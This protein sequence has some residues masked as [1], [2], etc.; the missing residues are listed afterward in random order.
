[1]IEAKRQ[2]KEFKKW[3]LFF[4]L[5]IIGFF[6]SE[7][8]IWNIASF[9]HILSESI[10]KAVVLSLIGILIYV[11]LFVFFTDVIRR[12][13]INDF[14]GLVLLGSVYGLLLEGIFA[15]KVFNL[16]GF[17][18][19]IAG[20]W[21]SNL[22]FTALSWHPLID[23]LGAFF[24]LK[25]FL[26][27]KISSSPDNIN[28]KEGTVIFFFS[29]FWFV[30]SFAPWL[31]AKMPEE[32]PL[33][34]EIFF[35]LF[36]AILIL[37]GYFILKTKINQLPE[38]FLGKKFYFLFVIVFLIFS[39][40]RFNDL[41][42]K[43]SFLFFW[44]IIF[45]YIFLFLLYAKSRKEKEKS[46]L[47]DSFP[48][49]NEMSFKKMVKIMFFFYFCYFV[50]KVVVLYFPLQQYFTLLNIFLYSLFLFFVPF[51]FFLAIFKITWNLIKK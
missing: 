40:L 22:A 29:F 25:I 12:F 28:L 21:G 3:F 45:L 41:D 30:F 7:I 42:N 17:S 39:I 48:I 32:L 23:F 34:A 43:K 26:K 8:L 51:F 31:L 13:K 18:F 44:L 4:F 15:D 1:M 46:I 2:S 37:I 50:F 36:P 33:L 9:S 19:N 47:D 14:V 11:V 16:N 10:A 20:I 6:L 49:T 38:K 24:L 35:L 27:G 5:G